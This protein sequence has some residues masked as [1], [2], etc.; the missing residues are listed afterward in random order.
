MVDM[1]LSSSR[2]GEREPESRNI[3]ADPDSRLRV[4]PHDAGS[5][6]GTIPPAGRNRLFPA[7]VRGGGGNAGVPAPVFPTAV[8][9]CF[10]ER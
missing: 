1:I 9:V 10:S 7:V 3:S 8:T 4:L 6:P 5:T 2:P